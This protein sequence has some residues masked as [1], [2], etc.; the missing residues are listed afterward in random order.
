MT[1]LVGS[2]MIMKDRNE[3]ISKFLSLVLRHKPETI[4]LHLDANGWASVEELISGMRAKGS[5]LTIEQLTQVVETN[6]KKRFIFSEDRSRIRANQGH[7][8][9]VNLQLRE[10]KPPE[11]LLH[12]TATRNIE[13]IRQRGLLKGERHH[14]HLSE[15]KE[16]ALIVG[17]RYGK[18]VLLIVQAGKMFAQ[19]L[20]FYRSENNVWLTEYVPSEYLVFPE[21]II[22]S[23]K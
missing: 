22:N 7:S 18:P 13:S 9:D 1:C 14:V 19:G 2:R 17:A 4:G 12:G 6:E 11:V 3:S 16:S 10:V 21:D 5:P 8:I 23:H 20:K 15:S